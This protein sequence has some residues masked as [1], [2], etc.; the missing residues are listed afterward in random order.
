MTFVFLLSLLVTLPAIATIKIERILEAGDLKVNHYSLFMN[1]GEIVHIHIDNLETINKSREALKR[2]ATVELIRAES[3]GDNVK[4]LNDI[5]IATSTIIDSENF[6]DVDIEPVYTPR[7]SK[8][9]LLTRDPMA[10]ANLTRFNSY[11]EAQAIM[12]TMNGDTHKDSQC[13]NR[14]HVWTYEASVLKSKNL[15]KVWI[16]FTKKYIREYDYKWWF[17]IAPTANVE[18]FTYV[19]DRGFTRI[20]YNLTNWKNIF[21]KSKEECTTTKDYMDYEN[22]PENGHCYLIFSGQHYY[23]PQHL[24]NLSTRGIVATQYQTS[25]MPLAYRDALNYWDGRIPGTQPDRD[26][27]TFRVGESVVSRNGVVGT[28]VRVLGDRVEVQYRD[29]RY[30]ILQYKGDVGMRRGQVGGFRVGQYVYNRNRIQGQVIAV[31]MDGFLGVHYPSQRMYSLEHPSS[32][33]R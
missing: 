14:A 15:G 29:R 18:D 31:Y 24:R 5:K 12:D 16:F 25:D 20:P 3:L 28:V 13:Y 23:Q 32:L 10:Y 30:S 9:N 1:D 33:R 17:H 8:F 22:N 2:S 11:E 7:E 19:V 27:F 26:V 21:I 4:I 6:Y